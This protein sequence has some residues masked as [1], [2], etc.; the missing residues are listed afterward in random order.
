MFKIIISTLKG[1]SRLNLILD[2]ILDT[3]SFKAPFH[4]VSGSDGKCQRRMYDKDLRLEPLKNP[5]VASL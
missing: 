1:C 2:I 3:Y 5:L 4:Y